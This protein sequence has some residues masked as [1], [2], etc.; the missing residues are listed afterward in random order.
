MQRVAKYS[1][2]GSI[3]SAGSFRPTREG[4]G[5]NKETHTRQKPRRKSFTFLRLS[6]GLGLE[7]SQNSRQRV[8]PPPNRLA[9]FSLR[10]Q[11]A[12]RLKV[13]RAQRSLQAAFSFCFS[14][15]VKLSRFFPRRSRKYS[16][17]HDRETQKTTSSA[18]R[19][20]R[21]RCLFA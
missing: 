10:N 21:W 3:F 2:A 4:G 18:R 8:C 5:S 17:L 12:S 13:S 6:H 19:A 11:P 15:K 16:H 20:A 9:F 14:T 7:D 1:S